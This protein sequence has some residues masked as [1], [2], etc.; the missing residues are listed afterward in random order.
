M[1]EGDRLEVTVTNM[2]FLAETPITIHWHGQHQRGTNYMDGVPQ[3]TQCYIQPGENFTYE[4]TPDPAGTFMYH[5]HV[6]T[7]IG[8][9]FFGSLIVRQ[10]Q[11]KDPNWNTYDHD[12]DTPSRDCEFVAIINDWV[13]GG[14]ALDDF[15]VTR[16]GAKDYYMPKTGLVN[17]RSNVI[18]SKT[19]SSGDQTATTPL[20]VFNVVKGKRY[21]FR[22][23]NLSTVSCRYQVSVDFHRLTVIATDGYPVRQQVADVVTL[24][25]GERYD[26]VLEA[27]GDVGNYWF[28]AIPIG[29]CNVDPY[30][31]NAIAIVRYQGASTGDP[32]GQVDQPLTN[33][34]TPVN[35]NM[36]FGNKAGWESGMAGAVF[37]SQLKSTSAMPN[38]LKGSPDYTL[39]IPMDQFYNDPHY[40]NP[41][42]YPYTLMSKYTAYTAMFN[43]IS[44]TFPQSPWLL[45]PDD[46]KG[47]FCDPSSTDQEACYEERCRCTQMISVPLGATLEIVIIN[48][49][50]KSKGTK[51]HPIHIHGYHAYLVGLNKL[52]L[53]LH[54]SE[55]KRRNEAGEIPKNL[56][57]PPLK[58]TVQVPGGGYAIWRFK[59]DNPGLWFFHCHV[60][61][62]MLEGQSLILKVGDVSDFDTIPNDFP[63]CSKS[64]VR[65]GSGSG[66][67]TGPRSGSGSE[68]GSNQELCAS[69]ALK[70][71][72]DA[73]VFVVLVLATSVLT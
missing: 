51:G 50:L 21:R 52:A 48:E 37:A 71:T 27:N 14:T 24:F 58:D 69:S 59:A 47:K 1:C 39:Y 4:F 64:Q 38:E 12:C 15:L 32:P 61:T 72:A 46:I 6:G 9:G 49:A 42:L 13:R 43:N 57:D 62:H 68:S 44:F 73:V 23:I 7:Q 16:Y 33:T 34:A 35:V 36:V 10:S 66:T 29:E 25:N 40:D 41:E 28:K 30:N 17:G 8:D 65:S 63:M 60:L 53:K 45:Y 20:E 11:S 2:M 22:L 56:E 31:A 19:L 70:N 55:M 5:S 3:L 18:E 67:E 26:F 54:K